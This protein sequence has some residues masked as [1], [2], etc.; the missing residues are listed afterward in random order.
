LRDRFEPAEDLKAYRGPVKIVVAEHDEIIPAEAGQ[1]L[2]ESYVGPK[3]LQV[4]SG[5]R[6]ND[7][8]EQSPEWWQGVFAFWETKASSRK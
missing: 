3:D 1:R 6:H 5:A 4:V 2:F 7:V 8:A